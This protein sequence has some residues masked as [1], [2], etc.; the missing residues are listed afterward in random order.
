MSPGGIGRTA[1]GVILWLMASKP[2]GPGHLDKYFEPAEPAQVH[3]HQQ[4][5]RSG[6]RPDLWGALM[7]MLAGNLVLPMPRKGSSKC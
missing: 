6:H 5:A 4:I 7:G 2:F 1:G 3:T